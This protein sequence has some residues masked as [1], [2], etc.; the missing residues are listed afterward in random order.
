MEV[1]TSSCRCCAAFC[2]VKVTVDK[3][4]VVKVEGNDDAPLYH[5]FICPKGRKL[6]VVQQGEGRL[7][8]SLK[9]MEDGGFQPISTEDLVDEIAM[10]LRRIMDE[11]G[12][13]SVAAF[14][15]G[16]IMEQQA[17]GGMMLSFLTAIGSPMLFSNNTID[18]PG[19]IIANALHGVWQG[20]RARPDDCEL[21][22][23]VGGNPVISKQH[24]PQNPG[25]QLKSL[26]N[27]GGG[28]IVIDPRRTE[29]ARRADVHLQIIPGEDP[30]VLAG[31]LHLVIA[32][33]GVD[34]AFVDLN[35]HGMRELA[36][37][38]AGFTPA[39]VSERAGVS[40]EDLRKAASMLVKAS[41]G[42]FALGVGPSMATRGN[43]SSYLALCI[44]TLRGFWPA[45]G[46]EAAQPT[47]L[48]PRRRFKAQ[49][50]GPRPA[51][52]FGLKTSVRGLQETV[53]GMPSAALPEMML[54][55]GRD[56]I[57]ALFLHNGAMYTWPDQQRTMAAFRKADLVVA[58]DIGLSG[59]ARMAD[60]V[61]ATKLQLEVPFISQLGEVASNIHPGYGWIEPYAAYQA[62]V[63]DPPADTDLLEGWQLY[64]RLARN[65]GVQIAYND[66]FGSTKEANLVDMTHEPTTEDLY[67]IM[68]AGSAVPLSRVREYPNGHIFDEARESIGERD[69]DCTEKF[70]LADPTMMDE[71][72][73]VR[74]E[75][76]MTR[77]GTDASYPFLFIPRRMQ[78]TTNSMPR[79]GGLIR[80]S[81]NPLFMHPD[82]L[83]RLDLTGGD[84]VTIRS[85]HGAI[86]GFVES[87]ADLRPGVVGMMHGFGAVPGQA[88]D[89]RRDGSNVNQLLRWEDDCD[90]YHG[91]P[92]MGAVPVAIAPVSMPEEE[93][94][95]ALDN[96]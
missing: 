51:W 26:K 58:H 59:T 44:Q 45:A 42:A 48:L 28:L 32:T 52:G 89:P 93:R 10:K 79:V 17:A 43:L 50:S 40:E 85:R 31:L 34:Q 27:R 37:A 22:V 15:G 11:H 78:N 82:D 60:Y 87:D 47:V 94:L 33:G 95:G 2:P 68:C 29:T 56:R 96:V 16:G 4:I 25:R 69:P 92:R 49:P 71:I 74:S 5:G 91:M 83:E 53:A 46:K 38:T 7:R 6:P 8:H 61:V 3:D 65:L 70:E 36:E 54:T 88:Y 84:M 66:F 75:N 18:Q 80:S 35:A 21:L 12:P 9:R 55:E 76:M 24:L 20:G 30:T 77:R 1:K 39:Y 14:L 41:M 62:A 13:Q 63:L 19:L 23:V 81:Y 73:A 90:P 57:R 86:V 67:D 72:R 64:Y